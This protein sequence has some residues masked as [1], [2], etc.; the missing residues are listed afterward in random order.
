MNFSMEQDDEKITKQCEVFQR[1]VNLDEAVLENEGGT[2]L[3]SYFSTF[4]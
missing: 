3:L 4:L 2:S 1:L